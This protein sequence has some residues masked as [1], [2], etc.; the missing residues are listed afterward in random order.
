MTTPNPTWKPGSTIEK[1]FSEM[2]SLDPSQLSTSE[3]YKLLIGS[4]VPRP[5]AF[6]S[7]INSSKQGNLAPFSFFNGVCSNPPCIMFS[8]AHKANG[9]KKDTLRNIEETE[10]FVINSSNQWI[11]EA[12]VHCAAEYPYGI[13]EMQKVGLTP[14]ASTKI[15]P[16]RVAESA[17]QM[18]CKLYNKMEIGDGTAGSATIIVGQIVAIHVA[19]NVYSDGKIILEELKPVSRLGGQGYATIGDIYQIPIPKIA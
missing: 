6:I 8:V 12:L 2:R 10:E 13:D 19:S 11:T 5:I 14:I 3:I 17:I 16:F 7:T 18:E 15:S 9:E 4:I 1:P